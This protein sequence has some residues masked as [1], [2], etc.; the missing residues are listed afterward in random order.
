MEKSYY[1]ADTK[2]QFNFLAKCI[3]LLIGS[4]YIRVNMVR[5]ANE[6]EEID[7]PVILNGYYFKL[8][9]CIRTA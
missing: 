7:C 1:L 9:T 2:C 6:Y 5:N 8:E 3:R 4:P